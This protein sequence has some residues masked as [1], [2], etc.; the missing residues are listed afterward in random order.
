MSLAFTCESYEGQRGLSCERTAGKVLTAQT[1]GKKGG[2]HTDGRFRDL[3][4]AEKRLRQFKTYNNP[5]KET[6]Y[7]LK[8]RLWY[9]GDNRGDIQG[10]QLQTRLT[11][12]L[13]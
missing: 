9:S 8:N 1:A 12:V 6:G 7:G 11:L 13:S 10:L 3:N 4:S 5:I 2:R